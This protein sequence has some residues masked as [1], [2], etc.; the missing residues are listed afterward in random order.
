MITKGKTNGATLC[1]VVSM[2]PL[3]ESTHFS[4]GFMQSQ[5]KSSRAKHTC[6]LHLQSAGVSCIREARTTCHDGLAITV[7]VWVP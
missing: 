5:L 2:D 1:W 6:P 3:F 4:I 7:H